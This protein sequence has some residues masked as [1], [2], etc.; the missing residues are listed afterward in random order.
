MQKMKRDHLL[1]HELF[2]SMCAGLIE[3]SRCILLPGL[4]Y[5]QRPLVDAILTL[6]VAL[7]QV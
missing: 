6:L 5:T 4:L 3:H 7:S 2:I 1:A